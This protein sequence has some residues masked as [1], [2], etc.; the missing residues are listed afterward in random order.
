MSASLVTGWCPGALRPMESGDGLIVRLR[1]SLGVVD[2]ALARLIAGWSRVWG[3]GQIDLSN[4]GNLQLRGLSA[5]HLPDLHDA[6]AECGL[7]ESSAAAEAVRNVICSPLAGVD[8]G[9]ILDVRPIVRRL[10]QRLAGTADLHALPDK[11]GF[12]IDDGG[13]LSL[14]DVAADIRFVARPAAEGPVLAIHL[15]GAAQDPLGPC[16]PDALVDVAEALSRVFQRL[17]TGR[18]TA[19]RRM[20]DLVSACGAQAVGREAGLA[21]VLPPCTDRIAQ[22]PRLL[23]PHPL[24]AAAF[25]GVGLKFG[26]IAAE[27]LAELASIAAANG[28]QDLRLTPW[29]AILVPVPSLSAAHA[30]SAGLAGPSF[31]CDPDDPVRRIAACPGAPSCERGTAPVRNDAARLAA[32]ITGVPGCGKGCAHPGPAVVTLV[33]RNG[34]YDLVRDGTVSGLPDLRN[35]TLDQAAQQ[36]RQIVAGQP[37][38]GAA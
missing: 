16:R 28:A 34:R 4:R 38:G 2:V 35:I 30:V 8:P 24:G 33:C 7:L 5:R 10:E 17:R 9:A 13:S 29:R 27:D 36:V 15:A 1:I 32:A 23:G 25:A 18:H 14:D 3:N 31:I 12:A 11:F 6:L 22:P 37:R 26:R 21:P 20:R 19:I